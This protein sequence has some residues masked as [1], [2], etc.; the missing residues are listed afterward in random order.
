[1]SLAQQFLKKVPQYTRNARHIRSVMQH[2]TPRKWGNL[3]RVEMERKLRKIELKGHPYLLIIDPCNYCNLRCPLCPTGLGT[4][5]RPQKMMSLDCFKNYFDPLADHLFEAYMHN[6]G[7]SLLNKEV[8]KMIAHAQARNVGTNLSTNFSETSTSDLQ[9]L[10]DCGLEYLIVSL[11]G[12]S[13][14]VYSHYRVRGKFENV[15]DNMTD[16]VRMRNARGAK[17]PVVEWQFIV[18]KQNE[19]QIPE[20]EALAKKIGVDLLRFIP[21]GMPYDTADRRATADRWYPVTVE[22]REYSPAVEQQFGQANKPSPC[23]YLYRSMVVNTDGGVAPC[24]VVYKKDSDFAQLSSEMDI[25]SVWN[26]DHY[27]SARALFA[28]SEPPRKVATICDDCD[29]FA[30]HKNKVTQGRPLLK[31][32][33]VS[34]FKRAD[35]EVNS[36]LVEIQPVSTKRD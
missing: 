23:F 30:K 7:E 26:N 36:P 22:G 29:I 10:L 9:N 11:D 8:Y 27:L 15:L 13:Q 3:A 1:M 33:L 35:T 6:W 28:S 18:M 4:L 32:P 24:C 17:T 2:G 12:T 5:D 16:I 25:S 34:E 20:A 31:R 14:D 21:V 19:H